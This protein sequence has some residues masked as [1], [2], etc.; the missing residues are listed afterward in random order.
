MERRKGQS[1]CKK[2]TVSQC[3]MGIWFFMV[4]GDQLLRLCLED[5]VSESGLPGFKK[6][7]FRHKPM[8]VGKADHLRRWPQRVSICGRNC[9]YEDKKEDEIHFV[10]ENP[11]QFTMY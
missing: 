6:C 9:T 10:E 8:Y 2:R 5:W 1:N 7:G 11:S 3:E 4:M